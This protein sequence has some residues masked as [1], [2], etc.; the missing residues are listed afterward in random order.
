MMIFVFGNFSNYYY[1]LRLKQYHNSD[2]VT[3]V[4]CPIHWNFRVSE[5]Y[6]CTSVGYVSLWLIGI[7]ET[8]EYADNPT[9]VAAVLCCCG[10][11]TCWP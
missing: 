3:S 10:G 6:S 5:D 8:G 1:E 2:Q 4:H 11:L 9:V 7:S